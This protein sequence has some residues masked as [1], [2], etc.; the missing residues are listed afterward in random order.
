MKSMFIEIASAA[1]GFM[2][3]FIMVSIAVVGGVEIIRLDGRYN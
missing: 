1:G 3:F 2:I